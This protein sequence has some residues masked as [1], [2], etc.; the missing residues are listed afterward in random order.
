MKRKES[1][2]SQTKS[3]ANHQTIKPSNHHTEIEKE[4]EA[5]S[6]GDQLAYEKFSLEYHHYLNHYTLHY[7]YFFYHYNLNL[8]P[9]NPPPPPYFGSSI[10][11]Q[12][13]FLSELK[14]VL[15]TRR[16]AVEKADYEEAARNQNK[17]NSTA[18]AE[19]KEENVG[20]MIAH[21]ENKEENVG[22]MIAHAENKEEND[23]KTDIK[24]RW[25]KNLSNRTLTITMKSIS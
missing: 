6:S 22:E 16:K 1:E 20:E 5:K 12:P 25:V 2:K 13:C 19:N 15:W 4:K 10:N 9:P 23:G 24:K 8:T 21:T 18:Y 3:S 14:I 17:Y 7:N 11:P